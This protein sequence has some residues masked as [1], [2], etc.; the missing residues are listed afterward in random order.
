MKRLKGVVKPRDENDHDV[1]DAERLILPHATTC[2]EKAGDCDY[3]FKVFVA[4]FPN[5]GD[6]KLDAETKKNIRIQ[7]FESYA[8]TCK[9]KVK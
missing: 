3:A 5:Q 4:E 8:R 2:F 7:Q 1:I 9:G 6:E